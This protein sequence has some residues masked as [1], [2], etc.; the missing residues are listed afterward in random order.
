MPAERPS[1]IVD[2]YVAGELTR[3]QAAEE[4]ATAA[5]D[6]TYVRASM[7]PGGDYDGGPLA[8]EGFAAQVYTRVMTRELDQADYAAFHAAFGRWRSAAR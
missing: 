8:E 3:D 7:A 6:D 2:R 5:W 4:L 1:A